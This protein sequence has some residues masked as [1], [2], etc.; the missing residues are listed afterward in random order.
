MGAATLRAPLGRDS[1]RWQVRGGRASPA[2]RP[3]QAGGRQTPAVR[4]AAP[5]LLL[6]RCRQGE[7]GRAGH[8]GRAG[9]SSG[10]RVFLPPVADQDSV[11][12]PSRARRVGSGGDEGRPES[13]G[14]VPSARA[15]AR[16]GL[17]GPR[18]RCRGAAT[19]PAARVAVG[20]ERAR[21]P[22]LLWADARL[23]RVG[24]TRLFCLCL[25]FSFFSSG[26][27]AGAQCL[28]PLLAC[29]T[30]GGTRAPSSARG[31]PCWAVCP[32]A[33]VCLAPDLLGP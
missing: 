31:R 15:G 11:P 25:G 10:S 7:E 3:G 27:R 28:S 8:T 2:E 33:R 5:G 1:A 14:G 4:R 9:R 26:E 22:A 30:R 23:A 12:V 13:R 32:S 16:G 24:R 17:S 19:G 29:A 6:G 20:R 18:R 21:R